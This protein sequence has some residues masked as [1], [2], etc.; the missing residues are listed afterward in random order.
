MLSFLKKFSVCESDIKGPHLIRPVPLPHRHHSLAFLPKTEPE[1]G[2][3]AACDCKA[4]N[5]ALLL[6]T[7]SIGTKGNA[8]GAIL[9]PRGVSCPGTRSPR[10]RKPQGF[11]CLFQQACRGQHRPLKPTLGRGGGRSRS[12]LQSAHQCGQL[13]PGGEGPVPQQCPAPAV[14]SSSARGHSRTC[15]ARL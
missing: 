5:K 9:K 12:F 11:L 14:T 2:P 13:C 3:R 8:N 6:C 15:H 4:E 7:Q 10:G 1:D